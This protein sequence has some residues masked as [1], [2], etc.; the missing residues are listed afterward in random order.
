MGQQWIY[1][2]DILS[3]YS[4]RTDIYILPEF[5]NVKD[6]VN[7][8]SFKILRAVVRACKSGVKTG[9]GERKETQG[10]FFITSPPPIIHERSQC[11]FPPFAESSDMGDFQAASNN[12]WKKNGKRYVSYYINI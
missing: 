9:K 11:V 12:K 5:I 3:L 6:L 4:T 10:Y 1:G 2:Y 8:E 7:W